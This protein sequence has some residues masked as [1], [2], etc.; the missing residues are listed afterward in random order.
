MH[1]RFN[2]DKMNDFSKQ[3]GVYAEASKNY[4]CHMKLL[5]LK[6]EKRSSEKAQQRDAESRNTYRNLV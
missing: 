4:V 2:F 1:I 3:Y 5:A 6:H